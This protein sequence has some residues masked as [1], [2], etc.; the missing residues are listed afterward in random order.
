M[1]TKNKGFLGSSFGIFVALQTFS[2]W[3]SLKLQQIVMSI[4]DVSHF[5][6]T[7]WVDRIWRET[8]PSWGVWILFNLMIYTQMVLEA[9][10]LKHQQY[11]C[12][13]LIH[14]RGPVGVRPRKRPSLEIPSSKLLSGGRKEMCQ[15]VLQ[16]VRVGPFLRG[17]AE[18]KWT[19]I[20]KYPGWLGVI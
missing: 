9:G 4:R 20:E 15:Q 16:G 19:A 5:P 2:S 6:H 14:V 18:L 3:W 1:F 10:F 11:Y 17:Q 8:K 7:C 12:P 13:P